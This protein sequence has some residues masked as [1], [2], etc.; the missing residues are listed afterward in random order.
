MRHLLKTNL[1]FLEDALLCAKSNQQPLKATREE[2]VHNDRLRAKMD[3]V[4]KT[5]KGHGRIKIRR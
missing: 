5:E 3:S 1:K 4:S 2:Y